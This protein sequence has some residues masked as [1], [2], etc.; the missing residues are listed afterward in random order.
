MILGFPMNKTDLKRALKE[1]HGDITATAKA[2]GCGRA[3]VYRKLHEY[4]LWEGRVEY[5]AALADMTQ[6]ELFTIGS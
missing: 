5:H 4:D 1:N 6:E 2:L 3:T